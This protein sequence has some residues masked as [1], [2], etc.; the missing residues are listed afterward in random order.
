MEN[1]L[2]ERDRFWPTVFVLL[3]AFGVLEFILGYPDETGALIQ[4]IGFICMA[5]S[6]YYRPILFS[7]LF[8]AAG[9][10]LR[11]RPWSELLC[12]LGLVL[13]IVGFAVSLM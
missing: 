6:T 13:I 7:N 9:W 5:P 2:Q 10:K 1:R 4:G 12:V 11:L 3:G 8:T